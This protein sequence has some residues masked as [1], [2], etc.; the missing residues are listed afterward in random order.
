[1]YIRSPKLLGQRIGVALRPAGDVGEP[2]RQAMRVEEV[3]QELRIAEELGSVKQ[4]DE[5][6]ARVESHRLPSPH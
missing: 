6:R 2:S 3:A 4:V 5:E 1:M